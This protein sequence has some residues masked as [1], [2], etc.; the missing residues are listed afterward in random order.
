ML[1]VAVDIRKD[2]ATFGQY[3]SVELSEENHRMLL[4]PRG[5]AHGFSVLSK[6]AKFFYKCDNIY[7]KQSES[8]IRFDDPDIN[9]DWKIPN[10]KTIISEKDATLPFFKEF[11]L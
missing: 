10:S 3:V 6:K 7:C 5:F 4:I 11:Y 8:G 1:D 9:I 2:S